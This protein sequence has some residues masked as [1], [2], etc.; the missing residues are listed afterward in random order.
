MAQLRVIEAMIPSEK[1]WVT[2][3]V[4]PRNDFLTVVNPKPPDLNAN[5]TKV[6][7]PSSQAFSLRGD[8]VFVQNV[9]AA[10]RRFSVRFIKAS[11]ARLIA[12]AIA[13]W[14]IRPS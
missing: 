8:N 9:Y 4:K 7:T 6:D 10:R 13:S 11:R 3:A 12:S 14:L 1:G 2:E 5:T